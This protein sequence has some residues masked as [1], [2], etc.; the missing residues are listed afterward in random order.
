MT[1]CRRSIARRVCVVIFIFSFLRSLYL[2][3]MYTRNCYKGFDQKKNRVLDVYEFLISLA[4][5]YLIILI[6]NISLIRSLKKQNNL[7]SVS[8]S[9]SNNLSLLSR[10]RSNSNGVVNGTQQQ[11]SAQASTTTGLKKK[12]KPKFR[13]FS[14]PRNDAPAQQD[15]NPVLLELS[16]KINSSKKSTQSLHHTQEEV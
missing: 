9:L 14:S 8:Y 10:G 5:P 11:Q 7:M 1:I 13:R 15:P 2:P 6:A 4:I 3:L 12:L 16:D